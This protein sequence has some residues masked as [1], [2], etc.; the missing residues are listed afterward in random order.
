V[1][2]ELEMTK[3]RRGEREAPAKDIKD[4]TP[5]FLTLTCPPGKPPPTAVKPS[6]SNHNS[7]AASHRSALFPK[8]AR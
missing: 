8:A 3:P 5:E 2:A 7:R 4:A 1:G 6:N